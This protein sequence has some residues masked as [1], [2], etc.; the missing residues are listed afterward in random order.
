MLFTN[1]VK[2]ADTSYAKSLMLAIPQ[3]VNFG[4][5]II[6][7]TLNWVKVSGI[8]KAKGGEQYLTLGNFYYDANTK[9]K[10]IQPTG[11]FNAG[12]YVD[13]VA[14]YD[15]DSFCLQADAGRD[16]TININD[17]VYIGSYTNGI[18]TIKWYNAAG[19]IIDSTRPGFWVKPGASGS[20]MYVVEQ[21]VNGCY[22]RDTVWV[23][24]VLPL[25]MLNY[26]LRMMNEKQVENIW[27]TAD[28]INVNHYNIQRSTNAK[29]FTTVGTVKAKNKSYNAYEFIDDS[30][31]TTADSK[32]VYYRIEAID[33]DGTKNYSTTQQINL[34]T[35]QLISI[36]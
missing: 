3:V 34:S 21:T 17:S 23:N 18:D 9:Y 2:Y 30:P 11:I 14:V 33:K 12:Y 31:L 16:T 19:Q 28:E 10:I 5:P 4:N 26:E 1:N 20:Y 7:D 32:F 24:V 8:F 29:D 15:L 35:T 25:R 6:T 27:Q 22:S 36:F 13:D